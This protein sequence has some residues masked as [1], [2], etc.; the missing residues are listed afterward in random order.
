M[1]LTAKRKGFGSRVRSFDQGGVLD[2]HTFWQ[3]VK[4]EKERADRS[5]MPVTIAVFT[6]REDP[7]RPEVAAWNAA[8]LSSCLRSTAR[9]TDHVGV[10]GNQEVGVVLWGTR[11]LGAYRFVKRLEDRASKLAADCRLFVYPSV[12]GS[13]GADPSAETTDP[14]ELVLEDTAELDV[15]DR[16]D[17]VERQ[18]AEAQWVETPVVSD[19]ECHTSGAG[20]GFG[21]DPDDYRPAASA[22]TRLQQDLQTGGVATLLAPARRS[23]DET[24][25]QLGLD[26]RRLSTGAM[27]E[28]GTQG[29]ADEPT[30]NVTTEPLENLFLHPH[31]RWKRAMDM[32][33]SAMGLVLLCP[34]LAVIAVAIRVTSPGPVLFRQIREGHGGRL[35]TI[36]KF[37]TMRVGADA[38][39]ASL[40]ASSEQDG[41]AFKLQSDPRVTVLGRF[42]RRTCLDELP[43]L[44][45][46]LRGDMTLV[47]P[48]PLDFRESTKIARWGRRR[49]HVMPGLTCIWQVH[50]KSSVTFNEWMRMDIRYAQRA[51]FFYDLKLVLQTVRQ[52]LL[53]RASH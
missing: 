43:Q 25:S 31:P 17:Q 28:A 38:E 16:I 18:L 24:L 53:Q 52:M 5:G 11:E 21:A 49:L 20:L 2:E 46:V 29:A 19:E 48:R 13:P 33:V 45:N 8:T 44:W 36:L 42:L 12:D 26:R 6:V 34:L 37:R 40:R 41:P 1:W 10:A 35:F 47:G 9:M 27:P 30:L 23:T 50:G 4:T 15:L 14:P 22:A 51:S 39:K 32:A 3:I 7:A